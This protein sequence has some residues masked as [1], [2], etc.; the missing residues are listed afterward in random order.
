MERQNSVSSSLPDGHEPDERELLSV[1]MLRVTEPHL[2]ERL[3]EARQSHT[4]L[5]V[6]VEGYV[7]TS[8]IVLALLNCA[9]TYG[10]M[11]M[12]IPSRSAE[13]DTEGQKA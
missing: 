9:H 6:H 11:V 4:P 3:E 13:N 8:E 10:V 1:R 5:I 2:L 7:H 12:L